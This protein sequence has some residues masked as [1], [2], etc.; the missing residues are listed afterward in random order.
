M[1]KYPKKYGKISRLIIEIHI[2]RIYQRHKGHISDILNFDK[3]LDKKDDIQ[4]KKKNRQ[5]KLMTTSSPWTNKMVKP[6]KA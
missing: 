5:Q 6:K 2:N 4:S 3:P 1:V